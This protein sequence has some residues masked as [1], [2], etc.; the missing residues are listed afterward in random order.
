[1]WVSEM[2]IDLVFRTIVQRLVKYLSDLFMQLA[3][4]PSDRPLCASPEHF[5]A[6]ISKV[7]YCLVMPHAMG[8][9][10]TT[11]NRK[12]KSPAIRQVL[13]RGLTVTM[14]YHH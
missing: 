9:K 4:L 13:A 3:R 5:P 14:C 8:N 11:I 1:M 7:H 2:V 10:D 6:L 12:D